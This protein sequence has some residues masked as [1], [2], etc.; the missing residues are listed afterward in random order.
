[1]STYVN[2]RHFDFDFAVVAGVEVDVPALSQA[3]R[4]LLPRQH[5]AVRAA[6][7]SCSRG[8]QQGNLLAHGRQQRAHPRL[9]AAAARVRPRVQLGVAFMA[10][11]TAML[12]RSGP[13]ARSRLLSAVGPFL[14]SGV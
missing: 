9:H 10:D 1:M 5:R 6:G 14:W 13:S 2:A 11:R 4:K 8:R 7:G 12:K 3:A